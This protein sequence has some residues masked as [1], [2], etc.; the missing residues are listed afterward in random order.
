VDFDQV[1]DAPESI[2]SDVDQLFLEL[3]TDL[4]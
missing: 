2:L 3:R 4:S 1:V